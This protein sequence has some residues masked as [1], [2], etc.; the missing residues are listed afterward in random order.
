VSGA[1][2]IAGRVRAG[3][4]T[5][6]AVADAHLA[7]AA[8]RSGLNLFTRLE[9]SEVRETAADL[10]GSG[11]AGPLAGVPVVLKDLVDEAGIPTTAGS[12]FLREVPERSATVVERLAAAGAIVLGRTG[13]HEFAFGFSSENPWWGAVGNPWDPA[14]SPGGS[15][16]G[17]AA[18]VAAGVAPIGIGTDT[19][20]SIRVPASLCGLVGLKVTHGRVPL[21]GVFP[22]AESLDT[23]G[24]L[25][26]TVADAA[27]AYGVLAGYDREDPWS[28]P[29]R[30]ELPEGASRLRGLRIAVPLPWTDRPLDTVTGSGFSDALDRLASAGAAVERVDVP[31][32]VPDASMTIS[33]GA[34]VAAVHRTWFSEDRRRYGADVGSRLEPALAVAADELVAALRRRMELR[35]IA[36]DLFGRYDLLATPTTAVH[37]KIIGDDEVDTEAGR[38]P[39]R[40]ALSWFTSL[41]NHLGVPALALPLAAPGAPPPSL[42]LI[43]PMWSEARLLA[44]GLALEAEGIARPGHPPSPTGPAGDAR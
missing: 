4:T 21:R 7:S 33:L 22:L 6:A 35:N 20:G 12:S 2:A 13:L 37:R 36:A 26:R 28:V 43:G 34:E 16:G 9:P 39:Y 18:A 24:P 11:P 32:L 40:R 1:A 30:V 10:D 17:S 31:R 41:V 44:V 25:T 8:A 3:E 42:Q 38:E 19:G 29:Q 5:A 15:S 27:A 23:V 14:A